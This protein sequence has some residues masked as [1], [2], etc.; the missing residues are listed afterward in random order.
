MF[1][2]I[3][4]LVMFFLFLNVWYCLFN[5]TLGLVGGGGGG[6]DDEL[7]K[8]LAAEVEGADSSFM[9]SPCK[10]SIRRSGFHFNIMTV[11]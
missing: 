2:Y 9:G 8:G 7:D 3:H 10:K 1:T 5:D 11:G 4:N 6:G